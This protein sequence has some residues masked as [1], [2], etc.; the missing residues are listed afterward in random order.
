MSKSQLQ[1][2]REQ[3]TQFL[4]ESIIGEHFTQD[5]N[6]ILFSEL[7][8]RRGEEE[9]LKYWIE[10]ISKPAEF[11][12][13]FQKDPKQFDNERRRLNALRLA[14]AQFILEKNQ[15]GYVPGFV[16]LRADILP[17]IRLM[18]RQNGFLKQKRPSKKGP[19]PRRGEVNIDPLEYV[20][21]EYHRFNSLNDGYR[22]DGDRGFYVPG[23]IYF[24]PTK[25]VIQDVQFR[26]STNHC[27]YDLEE[28]PVCEKPNGEDYDHEPC[29]KGENKLVYLNYVIER[30]KARF[31]RRIRIRVE[32]EKIERINLFEVKGGMKFDP[33]TLDTRQLGLPDDYHDKDLNFALIRRVVNS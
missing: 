8:K 32:R 5:G 10:T 16:L 28:C 12:Y 22:F 31:E 11:P 15:E 2:R 13:E 29:K 25:G 4:L 26:D 6:S 21:S 9:K 27:R 14:I 18:V 3:M 1:I 23:G 19:E 17:D 24:N 30:K 20:L 33:V 7:G